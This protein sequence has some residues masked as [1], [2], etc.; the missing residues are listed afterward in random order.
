MRDW[1]NIVSL[2][3]DGKADS[4][5]RFMPGI[6][7]NHPIDLE[8]GPDGVLYVLEYGTYWFAK[9][10]DSGLYRIEYNRGNQAPIVALNTH[11]STGGIPLTTRFSSEGSYDPDSSALTYQW[12][13]DKNQVQSTEANP[14]FT[15]QKA[16]T[17]TVRLVVRDKEGKS[18]EKKIQI[19][20]GN[21]EPEIWLEADGNKSFY[22]PQTPVRY[23]L[24]ITDKEDGSLQGG[25]IAEQDVKA[26]LS[27][28]SMGPDLTMVAQ[29]HEGSSAPGKGQALL[30][31]SDC[32]SCHALKE[33]SVGPSYTQVAS[34]YSKDQATIQKLA[35]KV[36]TGGSG[37][38]GEFVMSAHPQL[39]TEQA[40]DIVSY[41]LSVND[42]TQTTRSVAPA[43]IIEPVANSKERGEY[44]LSV[45]YQ[46]KESM[47]VGPNLVKKNFH[48]KYPQ[49]QAASSANDS[50]VAKVSESVVRFAASRSWIMFKDI[51]LTGISSVLYKV[52]PT[53]I[54]GKLSL[55]LDRPDG[56]EL[57]RIQIEQGKSPQKT[58]A[59]QKQQ[60]WRQVSGKL[61][62]E[63]GIHDIYIVYHDP[64]NAQSSMWTTLFLDWIEFRK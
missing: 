31:K 53:Q 14:E 7:F 54:G 10:K 13:F 62:P 26:T 4:L 25:Q 46:D 41:I 58:G 39:S 18:N 36:I 55:H 3:Q 44:I 24:N 42:N 11:K 8:V 5:E 28:H 1:I 34:R 15:F 21:A 9:N 61:L 19:K 23:K 38:W 35:K 59:D 56:K 47:G 50:A 22:F 16:G 45:S 64:E 51:D 37:A 12:Y 48:F 52:D 63:K 20:A 60:P 27:Y 6:A 33:K 32:K 30:E 43:G 57:S 29:A 2:T 17:Y 40:T 49:L